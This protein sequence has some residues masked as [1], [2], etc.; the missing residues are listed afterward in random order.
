[1]QSCC[2]EEIRRDHRCWRSSGCVRRG[3][4]RHGVAIR[5]LGD[6]SHHRDTNHRDTNHRDTNHRDTN[7]RDTNHRD[8]NHRIRADLDV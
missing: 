7:H 1:M 8:T 5:V 2:D 4:D 6:T 3:D